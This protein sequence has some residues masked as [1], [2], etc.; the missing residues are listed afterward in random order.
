MVEGWGSKVTTRLPVTS[1]FETMQVYLPDR[2]GAL[3]KCRESD[4]CRTPTRTG[5]CSG[6][7]DR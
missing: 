4:T 7:S 2:R 6:V 1:Q 5:R 3:S